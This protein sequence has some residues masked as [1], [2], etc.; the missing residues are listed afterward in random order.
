M[1]AEP[2][3]RALRCCRA[4]THC[5]RAGVGMINVIGNAIRGANSTADTGLSYAAGK[6]GTEL[7]MVSALNLVE[8]VGVQRLVAAEGVRITPGM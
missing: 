1:L 6:P 2:L 7:V 4:V 5:P 3:V 8:G